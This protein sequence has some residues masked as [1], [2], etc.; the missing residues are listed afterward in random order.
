[1]VL[2]AVVGSGCGDSSDE[3]VPVSASSNAAAATT[4][5][6]SSSLSADQEGVLSDGHVSDAEMRETLD[7]VVQCV[8]EAG[9]QAELTKFTPGL[10]WTMDI[11]AETSE[12][13]EQASAARCSS[14][15][16]DRLASAPTP[17]NLA[18]NCQ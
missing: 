18:A 13:A 8:G 15:G 11:V 2:L 4:V 3:A 9:H 17:R 14:S 7:R 10:G 5:V 1:M 12:E 16:I 6:H